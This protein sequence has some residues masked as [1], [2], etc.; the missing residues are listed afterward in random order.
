MYTIRVLFSNSTITASAKEPRFQKGMRHC[1]DGRRLRCLLNI[2]MLYASKMLSIGHRHAFLPWLQIYIICLNSPSLCC[3]RELLQHF[4]LRFVSSQFA[5][6]CNRF[7][8]PLKK[9]PNTTYT[10]EGT[11]GFVPFSNALSIGR[12]FSAGANGLTNNF[13]DVQTCST[14]CLNRLKGNLLCHSMYTNFQAIQ[15]AVNF[16]HFVHRLN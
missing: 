15:C 11:Y 10:L 4:K 6:M 8:L 1:F 7:E 2:K 14:C 12:R 13:N 16:L 5:S 3:Q 9:W